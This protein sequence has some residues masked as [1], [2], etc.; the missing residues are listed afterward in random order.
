MAEE[1]VTGFKRVSSVPRN[2]AP[3]LRQNP[4]LREV[5]L[6]IKFAIPRIGLHNVKGHP[7]ESPL[8]HA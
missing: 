5:I 2:P 4:D 1:K 6:V 8:V 7:L 3:N